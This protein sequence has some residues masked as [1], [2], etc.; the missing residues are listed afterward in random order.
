MKAGDDRDDG[1]RFDRTECLAA[2]ADLGTFIPFVLAYVGVFDMD[3][4]GLLL[5]F[6]AALVCCGFLYRTPFPVQPMKAV[7]AGVAVH[8]ALHRA[9]RLS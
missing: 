3:P 7:L 6:G 4:A 1:L 8:R 2:F 9:D 5:A